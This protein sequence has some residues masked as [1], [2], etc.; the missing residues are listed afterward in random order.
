MA[1]ATVQNEAVSSDVREIVAGVFDR[2]A[3]TYDDVGVEFFTPIAERL[4]AEL[5]PQEG[6]RALDIGC[7]RGAALFPLAHAV[8]PSG[9]VTGIDLAPRM[10]AATIAEA[11]RAALTVD[12][13]V[14]D[15]QAPELEMERFD[16]VASSLV[17]FFLPDPVAALS[18]WRSL[19][20]PEGRLGISTFGEYT[21]AWRAVDEVLARYLPENMTDP[22]SEPAHDPFSSDDGV[23]AL[24]EEAGL[25]DIRTA[26]MTLPVRFDDEDQWYRWTWSTG[27]RRMWE[28]VPAD[29]HAEVRAA[30]YARL[31][32]CRDTQGRIGFDQVV[33]FTL[34]HRGID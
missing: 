15:A 17:L 28:A 1:V 25:L 8:G 24:L 32:E 30:A 33:R 4:V 18:A 2:A 5:E 21:L 20:V 26:S 10:V 31:D 13:R 11:K 29:K 19:L 12:I 9:S 6:E 7:G 34:G 16:V 27:E 23:E 14:G 3:D 22:G